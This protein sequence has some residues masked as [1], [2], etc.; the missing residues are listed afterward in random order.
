MFLQKIGDTVTDSGSIHRAGII[1]SR[2][3]L[4]ERY[5][6]EPETNFIFA[7]VEHSDVDDLCRERLLSIFAG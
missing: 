2:V 4:R 3:I 5:D 1:Y 7:V 6:Q